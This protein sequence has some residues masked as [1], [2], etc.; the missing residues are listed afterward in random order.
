MG[1]IYRVVAK[2][3]LIDE[4]DALGRRIASGPATAQASLK[5]LVDQALH[6]SLDAQLDA[7]REAFVSTAGTADFREGVSAF[8]ERRPAK[9][10]G[11]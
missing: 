3:A 8:L 4:V 1:L 9:F 10:P 7:E 5:R 6:S 11:N 2:D